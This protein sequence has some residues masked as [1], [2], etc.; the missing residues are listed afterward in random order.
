MPSS[1]HQGAGDRSRIAALPRLTAVLH[2]RDRIALSRGPCSFA[3]FRKRNLLD[4]SLRLLDIAPHNPTRTSLIMMCRCR[5]ALNKYARLHR[6]I[7]CLDVVS[8]LILG[9]LHENLCRIHFGTHGQLGLC[10]QDNSIDS[11]KRRLENSCIFAWRVKNENRVQRNST[12]CDAQPIGVTSNG[13]TRVI[14]R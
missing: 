6:A 13:H 5:R 14:C 2:E 1:G 11:G 4:D 8:R 3:A 9:G 10:W 7:D 12:C